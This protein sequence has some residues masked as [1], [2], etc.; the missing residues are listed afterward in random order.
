VLSPWSNGGQL[1]QPR[2][3]GAGDEESGPSGGPDMSPPSQAVPARGVDWPGAE[4]GQ[5]SGPPPGLLPSP[6]LAPFERESAQGSPQLWG[7][8]SRYAPT[9]AMVAAR[10]A[11]WRG[12][13]ADAELLYEGLVQAYP[14]DSDPVGELANLYYL[15]GK[16]KEAI[17]AFSDAAVGLSEQGRHVEAGRLVE[18]VRNLDREGARELEA[19]LGFGD[20]AGIGSEGE[21][22]ER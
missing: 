8:T 9:G 5:G 17:R 19:R 6:G 7:A 13:Y 15:Q 4:T 11:F 21:T 2:V 3:S 16:L 10:A 18:V 1:A 20:S 14:R 22:A 12:D